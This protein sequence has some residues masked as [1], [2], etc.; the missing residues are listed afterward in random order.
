MDLLQSYLHQS[1]FLPSVALVVAAYLL[2][3]SLRYSMWRVAL[4][5]LPGTIAHELMHLL[6]GYVL[7]ARPHGFSVWPRA[8]GRGWQLG[9]V[10]FRNIGLL[11]GAWVALAPLLLLPLAWV[12]L[13][14]IL[15]PLWNQSRW[16]WWLLGGYLTATALFAALPSL[17]DIRIGWRSLLLYAALGALLLGTYAYL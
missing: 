8:Q 15:L 13:M 4:L 6:V 1:G 2:L 7:G 14:Q 17:Q 11:N 10:S 3:L 16:G 9:S 5:A 12:G